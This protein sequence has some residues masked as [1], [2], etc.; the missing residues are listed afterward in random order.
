M[1]AP[2]TLLDPAADDRVGPCAQVLETS[3][4]CRCVQLRK[5]LHEKEVEYYEAQRKAELGLED[6][7]QLRSE[8]KIELA[9]QNKELETLKLEAERRVRSFIEPAWQRK[10]AAVL[11]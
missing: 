2:R 3:R 4:S 7:D 5:S 6:V 1:R 10:P 9:N 8:Q 11:G